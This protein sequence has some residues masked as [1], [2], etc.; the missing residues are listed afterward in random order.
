MVK[1]PINE[2]EYSSPI[3]RDLMERVFLWKG[4][5]FR[6]F[7]A[8]GWKN[9]SSIYESGVIEDLV[10]RNMIVETK[11]SD[12]ST[13]EFEVLLEHKRI[14]F[15]TYPYEWTFEMIKR[16]GILEIDIETALSEYDLSLT[17]ASLFNVL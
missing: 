15:I 6:G 10:H 12:Y 1:I 14:E 5:V 11:K 16:A 9:F 17:S 4:R 13:D 3:G 2:I 8:D 7:S